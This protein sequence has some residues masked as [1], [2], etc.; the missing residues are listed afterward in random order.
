MEN[1]SDFVIV[2]NILRE[3]SDESSSASPDFSDCDFFLNFALR[4]RSEFLLPTLV[5]VA[6][7]VLWLFF[8]SD[9]DVFL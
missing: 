4:L 5:L 1:D 9:S 2:R 3:T 7:F 8:E 6:F